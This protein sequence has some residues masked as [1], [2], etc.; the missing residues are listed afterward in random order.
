MTILHL[1]SSFSVQVSSLK[2]LPLI[3]HPLVAVPL[4]SLGPAA[5]ACLLLIVEHSPEHKLRH[6]YD[7]KDE[8]IDT[9]NDGSDIET[10]GKEEEEQDDLLDHPQD[11][12]EGILP[13]EG[14]NPGHIQHLH[15]ANERQKNA[16]T[17]HFHDARLIHF[18]GEVVDKQDDRADEKGDH[19]DGS[20]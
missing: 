7:G 9:P 1:N 2:A 3:P 15:Q 13:V 11:V 8:K 4:P 17:S 10:D 14:R 5:A 20:Q 18:N 6:N 12:D 16:P 19:F